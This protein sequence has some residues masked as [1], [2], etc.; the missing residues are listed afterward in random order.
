MAQP[1]T[2]IPNRLLRSLSPEDFAALQPHLEPIA[3]SA[4]DS[5]AEAGTVMSHAYFVN[6]GIISLLADRP[7]DRIE[8]G[9]S[10]R[11]GMLGASAAFGATFTAYKLMCQADAET[12][13]IGVAD[14]HRL[15]LSSPS[16]AST[17]GK[18]LHCLTIQIGQTAFANG[19]LNIEAR[20]ARW[21]LMTNDR[22]DTFELPLTHEFLASMLGTR[23]PGVTTAIHVLEG[24]GMIR[25]GRGI[26]TVTDRT[27]LESLAD[28][29]YGLAES[30]H[31]RLFGAA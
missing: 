24:A 14:L 31:A 25:A 22:L 8:V 9:L 19:S 5:V 17:F 2:S 21:V 27:K 6:S 12:L 11:E 18:Y 1:Q 13:R 23:R 20:L 4:R 16:L 30:E 29:A 15:T 26:I 7:D 28:G 10:G 3:F